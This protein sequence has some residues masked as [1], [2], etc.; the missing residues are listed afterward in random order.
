LWK[1]PFSPHPTKA[2]HIRLNIKRTTVPFF[3][4]ESTVLQEFIPAGQTIKP[5]LLLRGFATCEEGIPPKMYG[6]TIE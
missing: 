5:V 3:D 2:R 6:I 4:C 1:S